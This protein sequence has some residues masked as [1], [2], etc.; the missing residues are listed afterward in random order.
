MGAAYDVRVRAVRSNGVQGA[1]SQVDNT[2]ISG[3]TTAPSA[4]SGVAATAQAGA[5]KVEWTAPSDDDFRMARLFRNTTNNSGTATAITDVYGFPG[6]PGT[7]TDTVASGATRYYWLKAIDA[8]AGNL[9]GFSS[10]VN[11]TAL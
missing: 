11:A 5:I 8:P 4:P 10:G 1:W 3:D 6:Q 7:Y 9:S 2:T